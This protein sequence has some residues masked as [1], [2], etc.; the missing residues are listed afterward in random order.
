MKKI[1]EKI[2]AICNDALMY[3]YSGLFIAIEIYN[4][5]IEMII[6]KTGPAWLVIFISINNRYNLIGVAKKY[7]NRIDNIMLAHFA[8]VLFYI[9]SVHI[10]TNDLYQTMYY[11]VFLVLLLYFVPDIGIKCIMNKNSTPLLD[12]RGVFFIF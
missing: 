3:F 8:I 11:S 7:K 10:L 1:K 9:P 6:A 12:G 5:S 4:D 2:Y